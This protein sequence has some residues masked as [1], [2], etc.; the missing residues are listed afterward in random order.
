MNRLFFIGIVFP[1][2]LL[3]LPSGAQTADALAAFDSG[4]VETGN[5]FVL[6]LSVPENLGQPDEVDFSSW[7][8]LLP[9]QNRL[10]ATDWQRRDGRW[11][12]DMMLVAFDSADL[13]LPPLG[14]SL[15]NGNIVQTNP[16]EIKVLPS[17]APGDLSGMNGIK[18]IQREPA[19]W[20]D[21]LL[22]FAIIAAGL[23]VLALAVWWFLLRKKKSGLLAEHFHQL[24][25]HELALRQLTELE[26]HRYWQQ[27]QVKAYHSELSHIVREYIERRF[28][29]PALESATED[30][31]LLLDGK[32][33]PN[34]L[35]VSL[36]ELLRWADLVKF[37]KAEP[38]EHFHAQ[39]LREARRLVE[40]TR[41][42]A[43][44]TDAAIA[45]VAG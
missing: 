1:L 22:P 20:R 12:K 41:P 39:A 7:E 10:H 36:A 5:P 42:M 29:V 28:H 43:P 6:H 9:A 26:L 8:T 2:V 24:L 23:L 18:D 16:L 31:L 33:L 25:P 45:E 13:W 21:F 11:I 44:P 37:A 32:G 15:A 4:Y 27:G 19:N 34:P 3:A 17:P 40:Q 35:Q 38:P 30:I 14:I